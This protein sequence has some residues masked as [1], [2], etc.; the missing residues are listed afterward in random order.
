MSSLN[1][2]STSKRKRIKNWFRNKFGPTSSQPPSS[3]SPQPSPSQ[4]TVVLPSSNRAH[5]AATIPDK[6]S[7]PPTDHGLF[8]AQSV[9]TLPATSAELPNPTPGPQASDSFT[10]TGRADAGKEVE[11]SYT[12]T[13][14]SPISPGP[15]TS[16]PVVPTNNGP[17]AIEATGTTK[18]MGGVW[19]G[20][21]GSLKVLSETAG[22]FGPLASAAAVLLDCFDT[23]ETAAKNQQGYEDLGTDLAMLSESISQHFKGNQS[24][25]MSGYMS[26][27]SK[28]I[29][30][31]AS[32]IRRKAGRGTGRQLMMAKSEEEELMRHY[33]RIQSLFRQIQASSNLN[34]GTWIIANEILINTRLELLK[35]VE[36]A[37]YDSNLSTQAGRRACTEGTRAQVLEDLAKWT[38]NLDAPGVYW[39]N[40][41]AGTGK[42]TIAWT[43]SDWLK[44]RNLL[45][46]SF[47]CTRTSAD[48]QDVTRIIPTIACQMARYSV[49]FQYN[50]CDALG[51]E[52]NARSKTIARQ[53]E[54]LLKEP[55]QKM[56]DGTMRNQVVV[57][58]ALDECDDQ[59]GVGIFLDELFKATSHISLKFF[60]TSRPEAGIYSRMSDHALARTGVHLHDIEKSLVSADIEL[61]L[62]EV[63]GPISPRPSEI[64]ELVQSSGVL[65][66]YAATLARYIL[67]D[68]GK[69]DSQKRLQLVLGMSPETVKGHKQIDSLYTTVLKSAPEDEELENEEKEDVWVVLRLVLLA[70]EPI[71]VETIATLGR[72]DNVSRVKYA[73]KPLRSVLHESSTGLVS[74]L[75]AS[76]PD[77]MFNKK[78]SGRY[79]CD[80]V[81][82]NPS[83]ARRC[84]EIM[85]EQLRMNICELPS[86]FMPDTKV[87]DLQDRIK[88]KIPPTLAYA[89]RYWANHLRRVPKLDDIIT[90]LSELLS[91]R[92]LFWMEVMSLRRELAIGVETLF[93]AK[94]WLKASDA[95]SSERALAV[96]IEDAANFV[97]GYASTP[98][99]QSTPHIYLSSLPFCHRYGSVYKHY[100]KHMQGLLELKG[101]LMDR[102]ETAALAT[103]NIY[104]QVLSVAYSPDGSR[105]AVGCDDGTVSIRNAYD[106]T[107]L[108]GPLQGHTDYVRSVGFSGDG[109]IIASGSDDGTIRVWDVRSGALVVGP[110]EAH[111]DWVRSVSFS[112]DST[113]VVS[114]SRDK[115][116]R[117]WSAADGKLILGPLQG[118][119]GS[120]LSVTFSPDGTLI[121]SASADNTIRL[122]RSHDGNPAPSPLHGHTVNVWSVA[123]TPDSARLVSGSDDGTVRVWNVSNGSPATSP[124]EGHTGGI[125]SVAV[126]PDGT[127]VASGSDDRTVRVCRISDGSL[128]AGPFAGHTGSILSVAYSPDGTRVISGSG[129]RSIRVWNVREGLVSSSSENALSKIRSLSFST[130]GAHVLT[131]SDDNGIQ[132]WNL[133]DGTSQPG[134][135]YIQLPSP[136]SHVSSPDGLYTAQ[137]DADGKLSRV[138]C[139][140]DESVVVGPF[141]RTPRVWQF[142]HDSASVIVG[143]GDGTIEVL[144]LESGRTTLRLRSAEDDW[145]DLIAQSLDRSLLASIDDNGYSSIALRIWSMLEPTLDLDRSLSAPH[146]LGPGQTSPSIYEECHIEKDGWLV[147]GNNDLVLWLPSDIADAELSLFASLIIN[148]AGALQVPKQKL[149]VG[150]Q[151]AKCYVQD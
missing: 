59:G 137:T 70:E 9:P 45:A 99:S 105:V 48:C 22:V 121:A 150:N 74:T 54:I 19:V 21:K 24:N 6:Q 149:L 134:S 29:E 147:S 82:H 33:R 141:D 132:I 151:W 144:A 36:R 57:L 65:F 84:F 25:P 31:E 102:R 120:V 126:S 23:I 30:E 122:W 113:R 96:L 73:L 34:A 61:Y 41:M 28:R 46:A 85:K 3:P 138:V 7:A 67:P 111:T 55:L 140:V 60:V 32:E 89:C 27:I 15:L 109:R 52:P 97:T 131:Q 40:G 91:C 95:G 139:T 146:T 103:W 13:V 43:F 129:D 11:A 78:R 83:I 77:F 123:F 108:V 116:I 90:A 135:A 101:S 88:A 12:T 51:E 58:D 104:S 106:G 127:L 86:S 136:S 53:L 38:N 62:K 20:L 110:L 80:I 42:T 2:G 142:S 50:L 39:M 112:P 64:K 94:K 10:I 66:I 115:T 35:S 8:T 75:H 26:G 17:T 145:V 119:T 68:G 148:K 92:L 130:D 81:E 47:F 117:I 107:L 1:S 79:F 63:L 93:T 98:A 71:G 114:G 16:T 44:R 37:D 72:I 143:F 76:F 69:I 5:A 100:R 133:T 125:N 18:G 87:Q 124:F 4:T 49:S 118:H 14:S 56:G 128:A